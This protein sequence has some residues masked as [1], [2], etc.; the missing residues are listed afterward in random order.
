MSDNNHLH[1]YQIPRRKAEFITPPNTL[2]EKVGKGGLSADVL[3]KAQALI[4]NNKYNFR[5]EGEKILENML[6]AISQARR[7]ENKDEEKLISDILYFAMQLKT[8]GGMFHYELVT[9]IADRLV[10]FLEVIE[11]IKAPELEII[12]GFYSTLRVVFVSEIKGDGGM[13][14]QQLYGAL[15]EACMRYF[16]KFPQKPGPS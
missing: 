11:Q 8:N 7:P 16:E 9:K 4:E 2:K 3:K 1:Y 12:E 15:I 5:P 6:K 14:G 10:Q 13:K